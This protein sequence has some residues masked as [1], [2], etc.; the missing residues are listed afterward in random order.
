MFI[1]WIETSA[2]KTTHPF[3]TSIRTTDLE[4]LTEFAS[5]RNRHS[6]SYSDSVSNVVTL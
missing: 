2:P 3:E 1:A 5:V 6:Q 4:F